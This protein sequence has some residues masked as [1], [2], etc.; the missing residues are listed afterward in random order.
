M[1][2]TEKL[3]LHQEVRGDVTSFLKE[4]LPRKFHGVKTIPANETEYNTLSQSK[5]LVRL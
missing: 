1:T 2:I 3:N 4:A 5:K